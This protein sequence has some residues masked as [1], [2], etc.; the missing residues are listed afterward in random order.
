MGQSP[1]VTPQL[2]RKGDNVAR[3]SEGYLGALWQCR[4]STGPTSSLKLGVLAARI[5][6]LSTSWYLSFEN[7]TRRLRDSIRKEEADFVLLNS[8]K[9]TFMLRSAS[10]CNF[11]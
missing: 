4:G 10:V 7:V 9:S 3:T 11:L 6:F 8:A 5:S 2:S 1:E